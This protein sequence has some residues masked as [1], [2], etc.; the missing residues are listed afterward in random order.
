[1]HGPADEPFRV[2]VFKDIHSPYVYAYHQV[3]EVA[4]RRPGRLY[5]HLR[6]VILR[7]AYILLGQR[8]VICISGFLLLELRLP[9]AGPFV[10]LDDQP[11][12]VFFSPGGF[13]VHEIHTGVV[14][15]AVEPGLEAQDAAGIC[16]LHITGHHI[17]PK[18]IIVVQ[19]VQHKIVLFVKDDI[20][21]L[22]GER[23][24]GDE[25]QIPFPLRAGVV[26]F[27]R[28]CPVYPHLYLPADGVDI[29]RGVG[30]LDNSDYL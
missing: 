11:V 6:P 14:H 19:E 24:A 5:C 23:L 1:M 22:R 28:E 3:I 12:S 4:F 18:I 7:N 26:T 21:E 2:L 25:S 17:G 30:V 13:P 10:F 27:E 9:L 8:L 20:R 16:H 15:I 29:E